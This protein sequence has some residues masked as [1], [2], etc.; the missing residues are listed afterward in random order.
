MTR[1]F[2]SALSVVW[3]LWSPSALSADAQAF[4]GSW[5]VDVTKLPIPEPPA[6]V[7]ITWSDAGGGKVSMSV[8]ILD[9]QGVK[10]HADSTFALDGSPT[11]AAGS[12]D[13]DIVSM[14]LPADRVLI[15]GAGMKGNPSNTRIFVVSDDGK[16]MSETIVSHG[17]GNIPATRINEWTRR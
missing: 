17:P 7:T 9:R 13:V 12:L 2:L 4:F 1:S 10:T 15:M 11:R 16:R 6:S 14:T 8:D 3:I 5:Q